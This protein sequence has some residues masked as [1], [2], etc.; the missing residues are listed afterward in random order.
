LAAKCPLPAASIFVVDMTLIDLW[1][2]LIAASALVAL[3]MLH[4]SS[5]S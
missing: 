1:L 5:A 2:I 4:Q 3:Y